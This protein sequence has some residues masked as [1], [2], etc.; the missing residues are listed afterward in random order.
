MSELLKNLK[1]TERRKEESLTKVENL[2][3]SVTQLEEEKAG[4]DGKL[5]NMHEQINQ[6]RDQKRL[7]EERLNRTETALTLQV[8]N[9]LDW[10]L[11]S[12]TA[13]YIK[14]DYPGFENVTSGNKSVPSQSRYRFPPIIKALDAGFGW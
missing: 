12:I 13:F 8:R 5:R 7:T 3:R 2:Q 10:V 14:S 9:D 4:L 11:Y 1:E 6:L